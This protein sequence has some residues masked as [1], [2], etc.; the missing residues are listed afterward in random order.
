VSP[1]KKSE[2]ME[3]LDTLNTCII[4]LVSAL[5]ALIASFVAIYKAKITENNFNAAQE[6]LF[7]S[8]EE[9]EKLKKV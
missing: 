3:C 8:E 7:K 4:A 6:I 2:T 1:T 9:K 5:G